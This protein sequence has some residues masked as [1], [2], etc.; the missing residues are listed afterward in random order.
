MA[1]R[2]FEKDDTLREKRTFDPARS[3][4]RALDQY[5]CRDIRLLPHADH[6]SGLSPFRTPL[7]YL[8][9]PANDGLLSACQRET[10]ERTPPL[11]SSKQ[12]SR[13]SRDGALFFDSTSFKGAAY[14]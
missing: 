9:D 13:T 5:R 1:V 14:D 12:Q 8:P 2:P 7:R 10:K 11:V 6:S 4:Y 3:D